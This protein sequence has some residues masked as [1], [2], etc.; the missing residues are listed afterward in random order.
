MEPIN[1]NTHMKNIAAKVDVT[2]I[3]GLVGDSDSFR[4]QRDGISIGTRENSKVSF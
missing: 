1:A 2:K 3:D 4:A